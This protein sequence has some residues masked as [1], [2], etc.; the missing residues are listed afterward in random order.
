MGVSKSTGK[1]S[2]LFEL[3]N[4]NPP[5]YNA[6]TAIT[7]FQGL[8]LLNTRFFI[9]GYRLTNCSRLSSGLANCSCLSGPI[10]TYQRATAILRN[11]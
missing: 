7:A 8:F 6:T 10:L 3:T 1:V 9:L 2:D 11:E 5:Y 4:E